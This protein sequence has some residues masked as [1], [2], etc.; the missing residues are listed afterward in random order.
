MLATR[1]KLSE[2]QAIISEA[3]VRCPA[4]PGERGVC[5]AWLLLSLTDGQE[6]PTPW[7]G[8]VPDAN[9]GKKSSFLVTITGFPG[10]LNDTR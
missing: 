5:S 4:F 9:V 8:G 6:R 2:L 3:L 7:C 10:M 1:P